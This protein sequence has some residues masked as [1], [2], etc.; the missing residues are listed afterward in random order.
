MIEPVLIR[1]LSPFEHA[2]LILMCAGNSN[3]AIARYTAHSAKVIENTIS[4]SARAFG[5]TS[6]ED[7]N[8]RISLALAYRCRFGDE[9]G[10]NFGHE[11]ECAEIGLDHKCHLHPSV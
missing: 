9:A 7:N 5:I 2:V 10:N 11:C 1:E 8:I 6:D 4:R 3:A